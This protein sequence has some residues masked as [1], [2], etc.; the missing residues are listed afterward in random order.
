MSGKIRNAIVATLEAITSGSVRE[1]I[2]AERKRLAEEGEREKQLEAARIPLLESGT[3]AELDKVEASINESRAAQLRIQER[4]ELLTKRL[5][6]REQQEHQAKFD[7]LRERAERLRE[8]GEQL[9]RE[10]YAKAAGELAKV[11]NKLRAVDELIE[12]TNYALARAG[13]ATVGHTNAIRCTRGH[14]EQVK[15]KRKVG[16]GDP[17]HPYYGRAQFP[18]NRTSDTPGGDWNPEVIADN[19]ERTHCF[20]EIEEAVSVH[21]TAEVQE[22]LHTAIEVLPSATTSTIPLYDGER[23]TDPQ[24]LDALRAEFQI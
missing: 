13:R 22:V 16:L 9:I 3:D 11:L 24:L 1:R 20:V 12:E 23:R 15:C 17:E 10:Q 18:Y 5:S 14:T 2:D 7:E 21:H 4:L 8:F 19:G 6:E